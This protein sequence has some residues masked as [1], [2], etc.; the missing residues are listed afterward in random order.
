MKHPDQLF[1]FS[2]RWTI[3]DW[4]ERKVPVARVGLRIDVQGRDLDGADRGPPGYG[5]CYKINVSAHFVSSWSFV[6]EGALYRKRPIWITSINLDTTPTRVL[7][8]A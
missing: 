6:K 4:I 2:Q 1:S 3:M 8:C 7:V 5:K